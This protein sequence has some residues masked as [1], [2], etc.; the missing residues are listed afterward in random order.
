MALLRQTVGA[1]VAACAAIVL[2]AGAA[3]AGNPNGTPPGQAKKGTTG[4]GNGHAVAKGHAKKAKPGH[5]AQ[6]AH[7]A[8]PSHPVTRPSNRNAAK[9]IV[10]PKPV[11]AASKGR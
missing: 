8:H 5:P 10:P 9:V 3:L 11:F 6:P 2:L 1:T 7:P 4:H